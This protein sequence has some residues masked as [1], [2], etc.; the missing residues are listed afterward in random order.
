MKCIT[1]CSENVR[2]RNCFCVP[3]TKWRKFWGICCFAE[4]WQARIAREPEDKILA[5]C[6]NIAGPSGAG[7]GKTEYFKAKSQMLKNILAR[8]ESLKEQA[9]KLKQSAKADGTLK[10]YMGMV[11]KFQ[12]FCDK[13]R[14]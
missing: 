7:S 11:S 14:F 1:A 3:K 8:D 9:E 13:N 10:N 12:C 6:E 2:N 4:T 5:E